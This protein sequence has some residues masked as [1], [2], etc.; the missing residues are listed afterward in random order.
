MQKYGRIRDCR[1]CWK[2]SA[3]TLAV[4]LGLVAAPAAQAPIEKGRLG[5]AL[6]EITKPW[7]GDL[8]GMVGRRMIAC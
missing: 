8:N 2:S 6:T 5:I 3:T 1:W 7:T 4:V